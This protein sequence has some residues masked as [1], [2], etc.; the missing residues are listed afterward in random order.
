MR[1]ISEI[2]AGLSIPAEAWEPYGRWVAKIDPAR[3][4]GRSGT[5]PGRIVLITGITPTSSGVGKTVTTIGLASALHA[6][7]VRTIACLRQPSLG[8]VFGIKGGGAGGGRAT[9]EPLAEINLGLTGDL[10]A[11]TNAH[12]LLAALVNNHLHHG[13]A[14]GLK[15]SEISWPYALDLEDRAL[16]EIEIGR[17]PTSGPVRRSSFVITAASEITAI[18]GLASDPADLQARL[19]RVVVG[20]KENGGWATAQELGA[21]GAM[22]ALMRRALRPNL[23]QTSEGAPVLVH[24][25]PFGNLSYGTTTLRS[26]QVARQLAEVVLVEAGFATDLGA[27]KFVDL[28]APAGDVA[29]SAAVLVAS[30]P[31]L[32]A[33]AGTGPRSLE[34]GLENLE[35]HVENLRAYGLAPVVAL[36]RF[37]TDESSEIARVR[38]FLAERSVPCELSSGFADGAKGN[39]ALAQA[40][41]DAAARGTPSRPIY[42]PE[43][44]LPSKIETIVRTAYGGDGVD[45]SEFAE[46]QLASGELAG[47]ERWPVCVAKTQLSLSDD[48]KKLGRPRDFRVKVRRFVRASGA[49]YVVALLGEILTMPGLPKEPRAFQ[50]GIDADGNPSGVR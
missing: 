48:P 35:K 46:E 47:T 16:R 19:E 3:V 4:S 37:P 18:L 20:R 2:V 36:N 28:V 29:P 23:L 30:L 33:H 24:G 17:G 22:A 9:M 6:R 32:L 5:K 38:A 45:L 13:N 31:C 15:A 49:G 26:L 1:P 27:E 44:P 41:V 34:P 7:G 10:E 12:N 8:P 21:A 50:I 43:Q 14:L 39:E 25:G 11:A 42:R 40:V